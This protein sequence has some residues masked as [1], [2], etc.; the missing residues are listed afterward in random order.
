M[1]KLTLVVSLFLLLG[2]C[3]FFESD[4]YYSCVE[5][6]PNDGNKFSLTV[7]GKTV[8]V[9]RIEYERCHSEKTSVM[10]SDNCKDIKVGYVGDI[11]LVTG[12]FHS[13]IKDTPDSS[14]KNYTKG[15]CSRVE[16][17]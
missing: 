13:T 5:S 12:E 8:K 1:K 4:K 10:F 9:G 7:G 2:G 15:T 17:I 11:E 16:K 14:V 6:Q 3:Q